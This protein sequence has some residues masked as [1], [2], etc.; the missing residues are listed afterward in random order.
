[1]GWAGTKG[2]QGFGGQ[3]A[4]L[5]SVQVLLCKHACVPWAHIIYPGSTHS[6][7]G[8]WVPTPAC[9]L[10][11]LLGG[12]TPEAPLSASTPPSSSLA[13]LRPHPHPQ[14]SH[15]C[16]VRT[17][18]ANTLGHMPGRRSSSKKQEL[19]P[20]SWPNCLLGVSCR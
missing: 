7:L 3:R 20:P 14:N 16:H 13:C 11:L 9:A 10:A 1:M 5:E 12:P 4:G 18:S 17:V 6:L 15:A 19:L 2:G 8:P